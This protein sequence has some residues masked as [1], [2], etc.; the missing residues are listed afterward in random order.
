MQRS[1][2]TS[3]ADVPSGREVLPLFFE[4][5]E[6]LIG[7]RLDGV[8]ELVSVIGGGATAV[9][10]AARHMVLGKAVAVKLLHP[11]LAMLPEMRQRFL[12]EASA[13]AS[14]DHPGLV[15]VTDARVSAEGHH[16]LVMEHL[17]GRDLA[18]WSASHRPMSLGDLARIGE[19]VA[20]ALDA[21]HGVGL[22]HRDLKPENVIVLDPGPRHLGLRVK[23]IDLGI[24]AKMSDDDRSKRLTRADVTLGTVFYMSPEQAVGAAVDGRADLYALGC[25]LWELAVGRP[26]VG[27]GSP[28]EV[29][30]R[31]VG[32]QAEPPSRHRAELPA[33]FDEIVLRC[34]AKK[35]E[36]RI[37]TAAEVRERFKQAMLRPARRPS[38][39]P[40]WLA[41]CATAVVGLG[42]GWVVGER[43]KPGEA[44]AMEVAAVRPMTLEPERAA[45]MPRKVEPEVVSA[46]EVE[47]KAPEAVVVDEARV[48]PVS[49]KV[50]E[51][52]GSRSMTRERPRAAEERRLAEERQRPTEEPAG[53][54]RVRL[55]FAV[56]P[57]GATVHRNGVVLGKTPLSLE[58]EAADA[59]VA[60]EVSHPER[61]TLKLVYPNEVDRVVSR[62]LPRLEAEPA[63]SGAVAERPAPKAAPTDEELW[64][65]A[66]PSGAKASP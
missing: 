9:V 8:Y 59:A 21:L 16:Y 22:V 6:E 5:P 47:P 61:V 14:V 3:A 56:E 33:W 31:Q 1:S 36:Q 26:F 30:A 64:R 60:Y 39:S 54:R 42:I 11:T 40:L 19:Q 4:D 38:R 44:S 13:A 17:S 66:H 51:D 35:P 10:F 58:V 49:S 37:Q 65:P 15:R 41:L 27:D 32:V 7:Y 2:V 62:I 24:V 63:S 57:V 52:K 25:L 53:P 55:T 12:R 23:V 48:A 20:D 18:T 43:T 28:S 29:L 34:L 46:A 50:R 45:V